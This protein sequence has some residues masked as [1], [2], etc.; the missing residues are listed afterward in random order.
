MRIVTQ[1]YFLQKS[2]FEHYLAPKGAI[3]NNSPENWLNKNKQPMAI[4]APIPAFKL[5]DEVA[6]GSIN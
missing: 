3:I 2:S 6:G 4:P 1:K 5:V